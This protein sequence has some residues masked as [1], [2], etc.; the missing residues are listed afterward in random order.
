MNRRTLPVL[1]SGIVLIAATAVWLSAGF[2][3]NVASGDV[4]EPA[5]DVRRLDL[6]D[7]IEL[8]EIELEIRLQDIVIAKAEQQE[9]VMLSAERARADN[10]A[11]EAA[12]MHAQQEAERVK[13]LAGK[14]VVSTA[15]L[16]KVNANKSAA[17][18]MLH[19]ART[20]AKAAER[21]G[22]V[23]DARIKRL[24]LEAKLAATKLKQL[25]RRLDRLE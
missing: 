14:S 4:A 22:A 21:S 15:E 10:E 17:S 2:A 8:A 7:G 3:Q 20:A 11:A 6:Q 13:T 12:C 16:Q 9:R 25:Q 19:R 18:A 5:V 1:L 23:G 24:E